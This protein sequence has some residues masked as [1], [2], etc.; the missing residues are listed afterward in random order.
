[1]KRI[2]L[3]VF[4]LY[5]LCGDVVAQSSD[6]FDIALQYERLGDG[7]LELRVSFT[8]PEDHFL[9]ADMLQ[10]EAQPPHSLDVK[11]SVEPVKKYDPITELEH[12]VYTNNFTLVYEVQG[13]ANK[14]LSVT[15]SYQGCSDTKCF[16][17]MR[18][19]FTLTTE[20]ICDVEQPTEKVTAP[21]K[22]GDT[23]PPTGTREPESIRLLNDFEV[24]GHAYGYM[25]VEDFLE[26]IDR[27]T[28]KETTKKETASILDFSQMG[29]WMMLILIVVGGVALNLTPCVLPMIPLNLAIIGAGAQAESRSKG[30]LLGGM[31]G[32]GIILTYGVL[33]LVLILTGKNLGGSLNSNPFFNI[34]IAVVFVVLALGM[35]DVVSIDLTRYRKVNVKPSARGK[36][37]TAWVLGTIAA[38]LAGACVA[39]VV[40]A[41]VLYAGTQYAEGS[42]AALLLPFLLGF[43]MALPWP[44][45]GAG[46]T[47]LPKPGKWM[48][49]VKQVFG[50]FILALALYY[51]YQ[52]INLLSDGHVDTKRSL[53]QD[54]RVAKREQKPVFIDFC[55]SWCKNCLLME[56]K[57]FQNQRVKERLQE[58]VVIKYQAE[59]PDK[60]PA[61]AIMDYFGHK[62]LPAYTVLLPK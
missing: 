51:A 12:E 38:L 48:L 47:F 19:D 24:G 26:F 57:T 49:R 44:F 17:P 43:G 36:F 22:P 46:M 7:S 18:K 42:S 33:G 4:F 52:G 13:D 39:P 2:F 34:A 10:V 15:A 31:Y 37:I 27:A 58:F 3:L 55:A 21:V 56:K 45:A 29:I 35:F 16:L 62:G 40:I 23:S 53:V 8:I 30:F 28:S 50:V 11:E 32:L 60:P 59:H 1:M 14:P 61:K 20:Q 41:V 9:Y 6:R 25:G 5:M 54:L